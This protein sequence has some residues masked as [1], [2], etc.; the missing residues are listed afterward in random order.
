VSSLRARLELLC[1]VN[2]RL[3]TFTRLD[4]L[5]GYATGRTRE[6]F[7]AEGCA[8]LLLDDARREFRFPVASQS[9]ASHVSAAQLREVRFPAEQGIAGWVVAKDQALAIAD[10]Q[11]DA[12]FYPGVDALTG[13]TTRSIYCA[14]L[15]TSSGNI[16]VIEV[17][18]PRVQEDGDLPFLEALAS[19]VAVAHEKAALSAALRD[20]ATGLRRLAWL[21]GVTLVALGVGLAA[22]AWVAHA[23]RALP[24]EELVT[25][26]G[27]L[28]GGIVALA[29]IALWLAVRRVPSAA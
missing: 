1:E 3:A 16:G 28:L 21:G 18:N 24:A 27:V 17:V 25:E 11:H 19:D 13:T 26:P 7:E 2:R 5:L 8:L 29:G 14:P 9:A 23:A 10:V 20:E 4:D 12:R 6:L 22:A 15:R